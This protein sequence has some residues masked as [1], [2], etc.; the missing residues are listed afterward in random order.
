[1]TQVLEFLGTLRDE[2]LVPTDLLQL[3]GG[4]ALYPGMVTGQ[5]GMVIGNNILR[6]AVLQDLAPDTYT[7]WQAA[8]LPAPR[9]ASPPR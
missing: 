1:M 8:V 2:G 3:Q 7:Q 5:Y 9:A 4:D 6:D